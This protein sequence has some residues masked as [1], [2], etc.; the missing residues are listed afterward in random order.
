MTEYQHA[1]PSEMWLRLGEEA[2]NAEVSF[3]RKI[4]LHDTKDAASNEFLLFLKP[5]ATDLAAGI[6]LSQVLNLVAGALSEF[7]V[8]IQTVTAL[9]AQHLRHHRIMEEHYGVINRISREGPAAMTRACRGKLNEFMEEKGVSDMTALGGHQFIA[10]HKDV[11]PHELAQATGSERLGSG[12]YAIVHR[13]DGAEC[14]ILNHFHPN[15]L[16][17]YSEPGRFILA[18]RCDSDTPWRR[19]RQELAGSTDPAKAKPGSLRN[20]FL[21]KAADLGIPKVDQGA[22]CVHV[23]A[24]PLE[25][26]IEI[27][28]FF[29]NPTE[30]VKLK[31]ENTNFG[32]ML[33]DAGYM[34]AQVE[35]LTLNP[36]HDGKS[37][38]DATE[39]MCSGDAV[40]LLKPFVSD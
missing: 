2:A 24:G 11:R 22:N 7:N 21:T 25:G 38:F 9:N 16:V 35:Q 32:R 20:R 8:R 1:H 27:M 19:L 26:M 17:S 6:D 31:P 18:F 15:Q 12:A 5:E 36:R 14:V 28:R 40:E 33:F 39:E 37:A 29:S 3:S 30:G 34:E 23:S 4:A 13:N 10:E